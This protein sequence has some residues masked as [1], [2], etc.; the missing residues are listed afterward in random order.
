MKEIKCDSSEISSALK[1][2]NPRKS[3][4]SFNYKNYRYVKNKNLANAAFALGKSDGQIKDFPVEQRA[5]SDPHLHAY[6]H[7]FE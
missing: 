2:V 1:L 7:E 5:A 4:Q 3:L 6:V